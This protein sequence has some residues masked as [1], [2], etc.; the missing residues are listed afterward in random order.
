ME[1]IGKIYL[2]ENHLDI[3]ESESSSL[4]SLMSNNKRFIKTTR[5]G[6][7]MTA[8]K[9]FCGTKYTNYVA[10]LIGEY[11]VPLIG[12]GQEVVESITKKVK[13][14]LKSI[15]DKAKSATV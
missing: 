9:T 1:A 15:T 13:A 12:E 5:L 2:E 4:K 14:F 6:R 7:N 11:V 8:V 10:P 3:P